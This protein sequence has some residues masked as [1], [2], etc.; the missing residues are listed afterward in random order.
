MLKKKVRTF[1]KKN[2]NPLRLYINRCVL[3][4]QKKKELAREKYIINL[5]MIKKTFQNQRNKRINQIIKKKITIFKKLL[6]L[7][8]NKEKIN[9]KVIKKLKKNNN[10]WKGEYLSLYKINSIHCY[11]Y[12]HMYVKSFQIQVYKTSNIT[13]HYALIEKPREIKNNIKEIKKFLNLYKDEASREQ[14]HKKYVA[15]LKYNNQRLI[16]NY[17]LVLGYHTR[18][19]P[20]AFEFLG[21]Y[22][23]IFLIM[24]TEI[25]SHLLH[26]S[27]YNKNEYIY[28]LAYMYMEYILR[29]LFILE[30]DEL[31]KTEEN[32]KEFFEYILDVIKE[33]NYFL[34][35]IGKGIPIIIE[36]KYI[37]ISEIAYKD[38]FRAI[39]YRKLRYVLAGKNY[40][41]QF[42]DCYHKLLPAGP[43]THILY[44]K[45]KLLE[46][47]LITG[48]VMTNTIF[49][50]I[51]LIDLERI[52]ENKKFIQKSLAIMGYEFENKEREK[53]FHSIVA[54]H[55]INIH[56]SPYFRM[57]CAISYKY[58]LIAKLENKEYINH[59][60]KKNQYIKKNIKNERNY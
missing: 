53:D 22:A 25:R 41:E 52:L 17:I 18:D 34:H 12:L 1:I 21:Y 9:Q 27:T 2:T 10:K 33:D 4:R 49:K 15:L 59:R 38:L 50:E 28:E 42:F 55:M 31:P 26:F 40:E 19:R 57:L 46:D 6:S 14:T 39:L 16:Y 11:H 48:E 5:S 3:I 45:P 29:C 30:C 51:Y 37:E 35:R 47:Y 60:Y 24:E 36:D 44:Q 8:Q 7:L 20:I 23:R 58:T 32:I 43:N 54:D 56:M 13:R